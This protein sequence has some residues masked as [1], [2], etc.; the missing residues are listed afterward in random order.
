MTSS[1]RSMG[2]KR[3]CEKESSAEDARQR[4]C[5]KRRCEDVDFVFRNL[6]VGG[7]GM[8][9]SETC[10]VGVLGDLDQAAARQQY[11]ST[12][13]PRAHSCILTRAPPLTNHPSSI[14]SSS[15]TF[16]LFQNGLMKLL[17]TVF[18]NRKKSKCLLQFCIY[19]YPIA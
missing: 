13:T 11:G 4:C 6:T 19:C 2:K 18:V 8:N 10:Q 1:V 16:H 12:T 14:F 7:L 9:G 3:W 5:V 15:S 17:Q